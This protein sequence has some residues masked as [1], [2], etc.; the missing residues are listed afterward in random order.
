[1]LMMITSVLM[2][3]MTPM[4]YYRYNDARGLNVF[5]TSKNDSVAFTGL[6]VRVGGDL[7]FSSRDYL[8]RTT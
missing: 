1:M 3:Q 8:R 7:Q 4:Q 5:E 2:A 6:G